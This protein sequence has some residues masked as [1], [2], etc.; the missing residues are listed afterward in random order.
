[1]DHVA[2]ADNPQRPTSRAGLP[3]TSRRTT[4]PRNPNKKT[5]EEMVCG[6]SVA[7]VTTTRRML[8]AA[9]QPR[10]SEVG[11]FRTLGCLWFREVVCLLL[12]VLCW[13]IILAIALL[14]ILVMM[15]MLTV[16]L[17]HG[18]SI[19]FQVYLYFS[20]RFVKASRTAFIALNPNPNP[21]HP[22]PWSLS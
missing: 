6:L 19:V 10:V 22:K 12:T 2:W 14:T 8:A 4:Q 16:L 15:V 5:K 9:K 20:D 21:Q 11:G 1:M 3:Q 18:R 17:L 7:V 13:L